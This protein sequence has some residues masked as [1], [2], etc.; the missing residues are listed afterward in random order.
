[1]LYDIIKKQNKVTDITIKD[2]NGEDVFFKYKKLCQV[3]IFAERMGFRRNIQNGIPSEYIFVYLYSENMDDKYQGEYILVF[4]K[5]N[6]I[7]NDC[8]FLPPDYSECLYSISEEYCLELK[9]FS[10]DFIIKMVTTSPKGCSS[11]DKKICTNLDNLFSLLYYF[12]KSIVFK[13][14]VYLQDDA[15]IGNNFLIYSRIIDKKQEVSIY[16]KYGFKIESEEILGLIEKYK[17]SSDKTILEILKNK[18][19]NLS[20]VAESYDKFNRCS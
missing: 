8:E 16:Q 3:N 15:K 10:G 13:G 5:E 20:M 9:Y 2:E 11:T 7:E 4:S 1:M 17:H 6:K 12:L 18:T 19:R 14:K